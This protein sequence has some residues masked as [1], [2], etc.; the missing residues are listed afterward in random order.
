ML[1]LIASAIPPLLCSHF[2]TRRIGRLLLFIGMGLSC[3]IISKTGALQ[4]KAAYGLPL[5]EVKQ[6]RGLLHGDPLLTSTGGV[7]FDL[8]LQESMGTG[9]VR[10]SSSGIKRFYLPSGDPFLSESVSGV[11]LS[12][13]CRAGEN[14]EGVV[15]LYPIPGSLR[16]RSFSRDSLVRKHFL[17]RLESY[18]DKLVHSGPL[19]SALLFGRKSDP[20]DPVFLLFRKAGASHILALSGMH[21][22]ILSGLVLLLLRP[23]MGKRYAKLL[24]LLLLPWYLFLVGPRP[25][26]VRA[27]I[28]TYLLILLPA[29]KEYPLRMLLLTLFIQIIIF[30]LSPGELSFQLSYLAL[31]G[32]L[33]FTT[34]FTHLLRSFYLP[35]LAATPLAVSLAALIASAPLSI[36][37]FGEIRPASILSS[38]FLALP[39][40]IL[41]WSGL[42]F[43]LFSILFPLPE[44]GAFGLWGMHALFGKVAEYSTQVVLFLVHRTAL[45]PPLHPSFVT[46]LL[47]LTIALI[48]GY[49]LLD[50]TP[51]RLRLSRFLKGFSGP[52][53]MGN[54]ETVWPEFS[55]LPRS[56]GKDLSSP[57]AQR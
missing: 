38:M 35:P 31:G 48:P 25:S 13:L 22:G 18:L 15:D 55:Y 6:V 34:P 30:P 47:L 20:S 29:A 16:I 24:L 4:L 9:G 39:V 42:M 45:L 23:L 1:L 7:L 54:A 43:L 11:E 8:H 3:A 50:G 14:R 28:F 49:L 53:G 52:A 37:L 32:I 40:L 17:H 41:I 46:A 2:G 12:L 10:V 26:L 5:K 27:I 51:L 19:L 36:L 33:I 57:G 44:I 21:V 56:T